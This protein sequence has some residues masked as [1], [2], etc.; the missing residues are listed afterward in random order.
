VNLVSLALGLAGARRG[1][2]ALNL[3]S[4]ALGTCL[5]LLVLHVRD[6][7]ERR[8]LHQSRIADLIAGFPGSDTALVTATL[9]L[10]DPPAGNIT[11]RDYERLSA[12]PGVTAA[13]PLSLGDSH[14]GC[15]V[16]G[17]TAALLAFLTGSD[18]G[19]PKLAR[20]VFWN[21][22][23]QAVLGAE[24]AASLKLG[25]GDEF[26]SAHGSGRIQ[27][28][29]RDRP[30]RIVGVLAPTGTPFDR[31]IFVS[32]PTYWLL[33]P[34]P[35]NQAAD[36]GRLGVTAVLL[37]VA[38]P[39]LLQLRTE[40]PTLYPGV[41]F[42]RPGET[43]QKLFDQL[44]APL[45][46]LLLLYAGAVVIVAGL[47][48]TAT[49]LLITLLE[50]RELA[51]LRSLG[52]T[53]GEIQR[54]I[55]IQ[56]A[57]VLVIGAGI[58]VLLRVALSGGLGELFLGRFGLATDPWRFSAAEAIALGVILILGL[59]AALVPALATYRRDLSAELR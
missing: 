55:L 10:A 15:K 53:R 27:V 56:A 39:R 32:N 19:M 17:T 48:I 28:E 42:A 38:R 47:G 52:A 18:D 4:I 3:L 45:E 12:Q 54:L 23:L 44:L 36:R 8:F 1:L 16:V 25:P 14:R 59:G 5:V 51:I 9:M 30:V 57:L 20:G 21:G 43:L 31:G 46:K 49:L 40:L 11:W 24:A 6:E 41:Q 22:D 37:R 2:H 13:W 29:H 58:G 33:H 35:P 26:I 7:A 34:L 50:R